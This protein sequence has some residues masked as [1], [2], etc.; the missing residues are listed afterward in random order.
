MRA[1]VTITT[2]EHCVQAVAGTLVDKVPV[3]ETFSTLPETRVPETV[4]EDNFK[5]D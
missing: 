2:Q 4:P 3:V 5:S 1:E